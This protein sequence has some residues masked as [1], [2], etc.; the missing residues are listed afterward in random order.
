MYFSP[1]RALRIVESLRRSLV[2][3]GWLIPSACECSQVLFS[4]FEA[5]QFA[6][7]GGYR[8]APA[9]P[10]EPPGSAVSPI[11][12]APRRLAPK[13]AKASQPRTAPRPLSALRREASPLA[14]PTIRELADQGRL[15]E[16]LAS[17]D[18]A[19]SADRIDP[20]LHRMRATILQELNREE[21]A[22]AALKTSI[23]LDPE[24]VS[25]YFTL[26]NLAQRGGNFRTGRRSFKN[27]LALL[28]DS[29]DGEVLPETEGLTAG[30][31]R[32]II[33]ANMRIDASITEA[34]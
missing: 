13:P 12:A 19:I 9:A 14:A 10:R 21:E 1:E 20:R 11:P 18:A 25:A 22:M 33:R 5:V 24:S 26:G 31:L 16:A 34:V 28:G 29:P 6:G 30:R 32:E 2:E 27:A 4:E 8:K 7:A 23:Y 15:S 3:G 17:C